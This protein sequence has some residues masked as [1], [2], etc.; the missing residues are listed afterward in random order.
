MVSIALIFLTSLS[1]WFAHSILNN[2]LHWKLTTVQ[3][4]CDNH[5]KYK[6]N[7]TSWLTASSFTMSLS[8]L[9][10]LGIGDSLSSSNFNNLSIFNLSTYVFKL[11]NSYFL[12]NC[13]VSIPVAVFMSDFVV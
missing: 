8:L 5:D 11:A 7:Y 3:W 6:R 1:H 12:V 9:K 10:S 13:D 2:N 4:F